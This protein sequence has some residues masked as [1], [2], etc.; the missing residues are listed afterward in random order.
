MEIRS[1]AD[2]DAALRLF[3]PDGRMA[4]DLIQLLANAHV[5][6]VSGRT[7]HGL[8]EPARRIQAAFATLLTIVDR[9]NWQKELGAS[10]SLDHTRW[11]F[12]AGCDV[13]FFYV[14]ARSLF[15]DVALLCKA[16]AKLPG[17]CPAGFERLLLFA[18]SD[19][20]DRVLG[21]ALATIVRG[22]AWFTAL[23]STRD[24]IVHFGAMTLAIPT[25][26]TVSFRIIAGQRS[27]HV[28]P[29]LM[30]NENL[31]DFELFAAWL[32]GSMLLLVDRL[33]R[34]GLAVLGISRPVSA[35][36]GQA[37]APVVR[38]YLERL[39]ERLGSEQPPDA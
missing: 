18:D 4:D 8:L 5:E 21:S 15:D 10:G 30:A 2:V 24:G 38:R 23:R 3:P 17:Q 12:F 29:V 32:L 14:V 1:R 25:P 27:S 26:E 22:C 31:A 33:G 13:E 11:L 19:R 39:R 34:M 36:Y 6:S 28:D 16:L 37:A 20:A 7:D 9:H 35:V